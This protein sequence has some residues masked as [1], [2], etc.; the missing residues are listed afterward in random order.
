MAFIT[1]KFNSK[2]LNRPTTFDMFLPNDD[3]YGKM[4]EY[5]SRPMMT[6]FLL[7]GYTMSGWNWVPEYLAEQYNFAIVAPSGENSFWLDGLSTGHKFAT[8]LG[9]ELPD[10]LTKTFGLAKSAEDTRI[11]GLSMGG[12]GAIHTALA[13]PERFGACAGLSSALIVHEV[14]NMKP[15]DGNEQANYEYYRECFGEPSKVLESDANPEYLVDKLLAAGKKLPG[16][17]MCCGTE[18][19]LIERNRDFDSFLTDRGVKHEYIEGEGIHDLNFWNAYSPKMI[20]FLF[21]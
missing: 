8:L 18:D 9:E 17:Y 6:L 21:K 16:I 1:V 15:G 12:F 3:I 19:F 5:S 4:S 13:Y 10:Y 14:A 7:H 2:A 11:M 20:E